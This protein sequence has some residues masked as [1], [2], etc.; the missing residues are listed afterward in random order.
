MCAKS[1]ILVPELTESKYFLRK[2]NRSVRILRTIPAKSIFDLKLSGQRG[3]CFPFVPN[4]FY[5]L[6]VTGAGT[7]K[8]ECEYRGTIPQVLV[9]RYFSKYLESTWYFSPGK[10]RYRYRY[11]RAKSTWKKYLGTCHTQV[12]FRYFNKLA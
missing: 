1:F 5:D 10:Y 11:R 9:P 12:L 3:S 2:E 7:S 4:V 6:S 8:A